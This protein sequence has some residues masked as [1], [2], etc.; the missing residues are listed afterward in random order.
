LEL[1]KLKSSWPIIWSTGFKMV[2]L[3]LLLLRLLLWVL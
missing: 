2:L 3:M 1:K